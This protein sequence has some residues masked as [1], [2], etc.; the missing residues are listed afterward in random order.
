MFHIHIICQGKLKEPF[1]KDAMAEYQKR[2]TPFC[3]LKITELAEICPPQEMLAQIPRN[4]AVIAMC[5]EGKLKSSTE[6]AEFF[7]KI[8]HEGKS[9]L[10]FLIGGSDGLDESV[11]A[12]AALRLSMSPMTFP[13]HL[14]RVMVAEQ[15]YRAF[16]INLGS[17]YHK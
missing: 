15:I 8:P 10:V 16:Q 17:K 13:H 14:A 12:R 3:K 2:L 5:V 11:K 6:L 1:Y 9:E 4:A 7:E